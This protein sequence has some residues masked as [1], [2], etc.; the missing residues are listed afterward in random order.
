MQSNRKDTFLQP[1]IEVLD[2]S[3]APGFVFGDEGEV[4][5]DQQ[6]Q[7]DEAIEQTGMGGQPEEVAVVDLQGIGQPQPLPGSYDKRQNPFHAGF[8]LKIDKNGPVVDIPVDQEIPL[9]PRSFQVA[10]PMRSS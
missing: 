2:R 4:D 1:T 10:R 9:S 5:P 6:S 7:P 3:I 8:W